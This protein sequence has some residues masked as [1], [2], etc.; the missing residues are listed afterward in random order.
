MHDVLT[1]VSQRFASTNP[2]PARWALNERAGFQETTQLWRSLLPDWFVRLK[3]AS[4]QYLS[5]TLNYLQRSPAAS[6]NFLV[7]VKQMLQVRDNLNKIAPN[8][9]VLKNWLPCHL[10]Y[11]CQEPK[12]SHIMLVWY[13]I[14]ENYCCYTNYY[15]TELQNEAR[16]SQLGT[17][18]YFTYIE[19]VSYHIFHHLAIYSFKYLSIFEY[20]MKNSKSKNNAVFFRVILIQID[21]YKAFQSCCI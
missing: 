15:Q 17:A 14:F 5:Q 2:S 10:C 8:T 1:R 11:L 18:P 16:F 20:F 6:W 13:K 7:D 19:L 21:E 12:N 4:G 9:N 3:S